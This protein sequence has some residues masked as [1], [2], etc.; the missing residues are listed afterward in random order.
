MIKPTMKDIENKIADVGQVA[1]RLKNERDKTVKAL[2]EVDSLVSPWLSAA[3]EDPN[4][5][6]EMRQD[7][8]KYFI[9]IGK[10]WED[11]L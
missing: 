6:K 11:Y 4:V 8:N 10:V 7:I 9:T 1:I 2:K 5:C 3:L